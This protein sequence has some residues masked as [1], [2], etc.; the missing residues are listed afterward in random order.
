MKRNFVLPV[1]LCAGLA[2]CGCENKESASVTDISAETSSAAAEDAV[3]MEDAEQTAFADAGVSEADVTGIKA[4]RDTE[5]GKNIFEI[6]FKDLKNKYE[7]EISCEN[8]EI[9]S[10]SIE[11]LDVVIEKET[12]THPLDTTTVQPAV[13]ESISE[14][15]AAE[16]SADTT[17]AVTE[18]SADS[19]MANTTVSA[20]K[21][22]SEDDAKKIALDDAGISASDAEYI[23][24]RAERDDGIDIFDVEFY[25][26]GI[27]YD[28]EI[29]AE[30]GRILSFDKDAENL[31]IPAATSS[32]G[33]K[34]TEAKA[35]EI[36]FA[37]AGVSESDVKRLKTE[38]DRDDGREFYEV[39][40]YYNKMEYSYEIS[41]SDGAIIERDID[42]D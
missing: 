11:Q 6:E 38:F 22:I 2:L 39:E 25:S 42:R 32:S 17:A 13:T 34:I 5:N 16:I 3:T 12:E 31:K 19:V 21:K 9:V 33:E 35:K 23:S 40:F 8:G 28:Y 26:G 15:T 7:Y 27:E 14:S 4:K 10:K 41:A 1:L 18:T 24:V 20:A 37:D 30:N 36:A 29:S